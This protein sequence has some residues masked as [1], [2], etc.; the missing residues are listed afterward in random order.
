MRSDVGF[1]LGYLFYVC[2]VPPSLP[3]MGEQGG[4]CLLLDRADGLPSHRG[5]KGALLPHLGCVCHLQS[6]EM[7]FGTR[8]LVPY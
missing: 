5:G 4:D 3:T 2:K 1:I 6:T 8:Y 7:E